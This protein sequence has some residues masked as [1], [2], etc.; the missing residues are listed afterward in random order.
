MNIAY[1]LYCEF[2]DMDY[3]D[4]TE[5]LEHDLSF[6]QENINKYGVEKTREILKQY[7]E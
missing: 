4:Y 2:I 6:I 1:K 7:F 5:M 3:Q